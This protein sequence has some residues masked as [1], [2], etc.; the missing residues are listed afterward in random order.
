VLH[1][2]ITTCKW[3][4]GERE[5]ET[6]VCDD[7]YICFIPSTESRRIADVGSVPGTQISHRPSPSHGLFSIPPPSTLTDALTDNS[8]LV[9]TKK[10]MD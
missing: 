4:G 2:S 10:L 1:G 8:A 7:Y 5:R 3:R 6:E 9:L